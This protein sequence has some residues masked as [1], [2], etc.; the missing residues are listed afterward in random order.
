MLDIVFRKIFWPY[1]FLRDRYVEHQLDA[2]SEED[3]FRLIYKT[4]YWKGVGGGSLSGEGSSLAATAAIRDSL[5]GLLARFDIRSMLDVPCGDWYWMSKVELGNIAYIGGDIVEELVQENQRLYGKSGR[6]FRK[7][8]LIADDLPKVDL[9]FVR[10][11]LVHLEPEQIQLC[12]RNV[13]KSGSTYFATT[14]FTDVTENRM[15][16]LKDRWRPL[17]MMLQPYYFPAPVEL[18]DDSWPAN[19]A[20][21]RKCIGVWRV[22]DLSSRFPGRTAI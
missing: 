20:D 12:V 22:S 10:D 16:V 19:P 17:N 4:G 7:V 14:T 9:I 5:S 13:I 3:R 2:L 18:L 11:C 1:I 6:E 21:V 15:P 8:N